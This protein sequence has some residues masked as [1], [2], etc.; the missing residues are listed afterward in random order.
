MVN[1]DVNQDYYAELGVMPTADEA[2]IKKSFRLLGL[3][4]RRLTKGLKLT[5]YSF[6]ISSRSK[7]G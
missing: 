5:V 6:E 1:I 4:H 7:P 3:S 2:E